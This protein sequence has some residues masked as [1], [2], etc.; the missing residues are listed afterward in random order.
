MTQIFAGERGT[1]A[2]S[3][4]IPADGLA[5]SR[6]GEPQ[7]FRCPSRCQLR[8]LPLMVEYIG[9]ESLALLAIEQ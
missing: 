6:L 8:K 3:R 1:V 4:D 7:E 9:G 2:A 5:G